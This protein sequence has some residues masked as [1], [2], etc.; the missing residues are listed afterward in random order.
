MP[1]FEPF[2]FDPTAFM[3][4]QT[5]SKLWMINRLNAVL[6]A[7]VKLGSPC[8][9]YTVWVLGGWYC[10]T[11]L[12]LR[13]K[14]QPC[15][16]RVVSFDM[17]EHATEGALVLNE[18]FVHCQ[19]FEAHTLDVTTLDYTAW[20]TPPDIVINTSVEHMADRSW[21][22]RIP[23][24][25]WVVLQSNDM[26]HDDHVFAHQSAAELAND[27]PMENILAEE[28]SFN[29]GEWAFR[30]FMTIGRK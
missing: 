30:R 8:P 12:L 29:Y 24:G 23:E 10:L 2:A 3:S 16:E 21:F 11:N 5:L 18:A 19:E 4:G 22:D 13:S 1:R 28:L 9:A 25:T 7:P 6:P 15:V 20:G 17:D 14:G 27:F 26:P